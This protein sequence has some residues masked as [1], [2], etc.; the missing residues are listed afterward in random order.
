MNSYV[1]QYCMFLKEKTTDL[2][3]PSYLDALYTIYTRHHPIESQEIYAHFDSAEYILHAISAKRRRA[4]F[5]IILDICT[6][7]ERLAFIKGVQIG[8]QLMHEI[9]ERSE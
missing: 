3:Y 4:L 9:T 1:R 2:D 8:T 5:R 6:A 7:Y